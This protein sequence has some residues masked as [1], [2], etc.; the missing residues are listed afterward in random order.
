[1]ASR[2]A[3]MAGSF[4]PITIGHEYIAL[5]AAAMFDTLIVAV[6]NNVQKHS[7]FTIEERIDMIKS[8]FASVPHIQVSAYEGLTIDYCARHGVQYLVRGVRS[9]ADYDAESSLAQANKLL[10]PQVS[11]VW[12]PA[13]PEHAC[14]SSSA[15]RE[16][17][18]H[19]GNVQAFVPQAVYKYIMNKKIK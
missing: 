3:L 14:I 4:D 6:G 12:I 10:C 7:L 2:T 5:Q 19:G 16:I 11:T 8:V 9:A 15:V 18:Y 1:M 17:L 13:K